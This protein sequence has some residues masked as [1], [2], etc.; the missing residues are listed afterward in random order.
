MKYPQSSQSGFSLVET[1][2]A[3]T[4]L[5]IVIVGPM[6][7]STSTARSTSFAS[8]QVV[9]FFLAQ[10]GAEIAQKA[11]DDIL[12]QN[13]STPVTRQSAWEDEFYDDSGTYDD[14][15]ENINNDGCAL[16]L[17]NNNVGSVLNIGDCGTAGRCDLFFNSGGDRKR[18]THTSTGGNT[19]TP[20]TRV[21]KFT[22]EGSDAV[23]VE[24]RVTWRSGNQRKAQEVV[25]DTY[26]YNVYGN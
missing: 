26:L 21:I 8:E 20:Y 25:V 16:E 7:I 10:E 1:L 15:F 18:Y 11:R 19:P 23:K 14:C 22:K 6:S 9:A 17:S 24:S 3:I 4:I 12:L 2:V 13:F 5:L